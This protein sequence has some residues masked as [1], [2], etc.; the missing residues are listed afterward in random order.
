MVRLHEVDTAI[1]L[2]LSERGVI[3][4]RTFA[5]ERK[6]ETGFAVGVA[7]A[8]AGVAAGFGENGHDVVAERDG[9]ELFGASGKAEERQEEQ[10]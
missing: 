6:F 5:A 7:V 3:E 9:A 8:G 10:D 4:V 1:E 2:I